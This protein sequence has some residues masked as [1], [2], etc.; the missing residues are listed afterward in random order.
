MD[1]NK[2]IGDFLLPILSGFGLWYLQKIFSSQEEMWKKQN[3]FNANAIRSE[4]KAITE[5]ENIK[6]RLDSLEN[7]RS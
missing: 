2:I 4:T 3:E 7:N 6:D 1:V 5:I